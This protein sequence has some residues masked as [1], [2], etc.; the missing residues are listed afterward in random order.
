MN[1][2][3][4]AITPTGRHARQLDHV[5]VLAEAEALVAEDPE[6]ELAHAVTEVLGSRAE[7]H[8]TELGFPPNGRWVSRGGWDS[9]LSQ[10][11]PHPKFLD[12]ATV[13]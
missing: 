13:S 11:T 4:L 8:R 9:S 10:G 2:W 1:W 3:H 5:A 12:G 7:A 6:L